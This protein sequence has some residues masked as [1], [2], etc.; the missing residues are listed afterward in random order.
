MVKAGFALGEGGTLMV[1]A[2][3][4]LR[5]SEVTAVYVLA[6][7]G[8]PRLRQ[9]RLGRRIGDQVEILAGLRADERIAVDPVAATLVFE[10]R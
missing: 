5:R 10:G 3:T 7:D 2:S 4:I 9:V 1:P 6:E 8:W